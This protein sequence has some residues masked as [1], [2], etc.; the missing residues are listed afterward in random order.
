MLLDSNILIY[1]SNNSLKNFFDKLNTDYFA[2]KI[3]LIEVYGFTSLKKEEKS[4]LEEIF[5]SI[6]LIEIDDKIIYKAIS[7]RQK[8][9]ISLGDSIIAAT[10]LIHELPLVTANT[11]DFDWIESLELINPLT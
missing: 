8:K 2:S 3:T 4:I 5:S 11:K 9:D 7:L 10:A 1:L 6:S